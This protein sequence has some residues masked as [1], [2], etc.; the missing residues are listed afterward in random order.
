MATLDIKYVQTIVDRYSESMHL[1]LI[2]FM[3]LLGWVEWLKKYDLNEKCYCDSSL[4]T[5]CYAN[6]MRPHKYLFKWPTTNYIDDIF[7]D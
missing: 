4:E 7:A 5:K 1:K 2:D 6:D 3:C